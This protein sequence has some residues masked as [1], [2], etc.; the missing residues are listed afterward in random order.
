MAN[1]TGKTHPNTK[2]LARP[3]M[4]IS[5][6]YQKKSCKVDVELPLTYE[7]LITAVTVHGLFLF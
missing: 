6:R 1:E 5:F 3:N 4:L 2:S 7:K